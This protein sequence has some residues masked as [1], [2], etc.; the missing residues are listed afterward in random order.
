[1]TQERDAP[2]AECQHERQDD[3][4]YCVDAEPT[5]VFFAQID[6]GTGSVLVEPRCRFKRLAKRESSALATFGSSTLIRTT[7]R[8]RWA[9]E[10]SAG[11]VH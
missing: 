9:V 10:R 11:H 5:G 8:E 3:S 7:S 6:E 1:M 2:A 4:D